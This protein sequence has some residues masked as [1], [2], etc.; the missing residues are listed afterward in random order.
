MQALSL[1]ERVNSAL[2]GIFESMRADGLELVVERVEGTKVYFHLLVTPEAC[3]ECILSTASLETVLLSEIQ[4][5]VPE[6]TTIS[7]KRLA[8]PGSPK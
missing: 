7:V 6:I 1:E 8:H 3:D 4:D 2:S 5:A